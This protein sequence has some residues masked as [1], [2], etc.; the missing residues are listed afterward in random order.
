MASSVNNNGVGTE[1]LREIEEYLKKKEKANALDKRGADMAEEILSQLKEKEGIYFDLYKM[2]GQAKNQLDEILDT[3]NDYQKVLDDL[4][5]SF[6]DIIKKSGLGADEVTKMAEAYERLKKAEKEAG[7]RTNQGNPEVLAELQ[8]ARKEWS[9]YRNS[10]DSVVSD[11]AK[12]I[13]SNSSL[14][15]KRVKLEQKLG[16]ETNKTALATG[17]YNKNLETSLKKLDKQ[18]NLW[19]AT[20]SLIG[21]IFDAVKEVGNYWMQVQDRSFKVARQ[22]GL[23]RE[24]AA[25]MTQAQLQMTKELA[26]EYGVTQEQ[27]MKFQETYTQ[28][29]GKAV[30]LTKGE[31]ESMTVMSKLGDDNQA[32][33]W[34]SEMSKYGKGI[35]ETAGEFV[36]I[37]DKAKALGLNASK[38]TETIAKNLHLANSYTFIDG[39]NGIT[40]MAL[41]A[42]SLRVDMEQMMGAVDKF[43][44]IQ[45][46]IETTA[47]LQMLGGGFAAQFSNPMAALYG[48]LNDPNQIM[49]MVT[50]AVKGEAKYNEKTGEAE[51]SG[52]GMAKLRAAK[53]QLGVSVEQLSQ[54]AKS[55]A[56]NAEVDKAMGANAANMDDQHKSQIENLAH[57]NAQGQWVITN[58]ADNGQENGEIAV[59]KITPKDLDRISQVQPEEK[60][61]FKDVHNIDA[62]VA[63][64]AG[65]KSRAQLSL[66]AKEQ[67]S[68]FKEGV[69]ASAANTLHPAFEY[70][71]D[72]ANNGVL[73][74]IGS[75]IISTGFGSLMG[76]ALYKGFGSAISSLTGGS[77]KGFF[78][79]IFASKMSKE[80]ANS[81]FGPSNSPSPSSPKGGGRWSKNLSKPFKAAANIG[82]SIWKS[83]K[84]GKAGLIAAG[85]TALVAGG[86]ALFGGKKNEEETPNEETSSA[87]NSEISENNGTILDELKKHT[88]LLEKIAGAKAEDLMSG[89]GSGNN[90]EN[91]SASSSGAN[92][93]VK[94]AVNT[95]STIDTVRGTAGWL[96]KKSV[97][98]KV[99]GSKGTNALSKVAGLGGKTLGKIVSRANPMGWVGMGVDALNMGLQS[100]GLIK[101]NSN[102]AK[103]LNVASTT[104]NYAALGSMVGGPIG[105]LIG[106]AIGAGKGIYDNFI[107]NPEEEEKKNAANKFKGAEMGETTLED[108]ELMQKAAL[109]TISIHDILA[110][111]FQKENGLNADGTK[112]SFLQRTGDLFGSITDLPILKQAKNL[113]GFY[114]NGGIVPERAATGRIV[115]GDS[116]TG[117]KVPVMANSG[118]MILNKSEQNQMFKALSVGSPTIS[119]IS[120]KPY[121]G[122]ETIRTNNTPSSSYAPQIGPA[123]ISLNV[124]GTI[125]LDLGGRQANIDP[126]KLLDNS[127]FRSELTNIISRQLNTMGNG[128][129]YNK[130]GSTINTMRMYNKTR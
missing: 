3:Y 61:M 13:A 48:G 20:L 11:A 126:R 123:N 89:N 77:G 73:H 108:P 102:L 82:K 28:E 71:A 27:L 53:Q 86:Y 37:Q 15:D 99:V 24:Q 124:S 93:L 103:G 67:I 85:A 47:N 64:L 50:N 25:A 56:V 110:T 29:T 62:N 2:G 78:R 92:G 35:E 42:Q 100:T 58:Y 81:A 21:G 115:G 68:G 52:L 128:G 45:S 118:E 57:R 79:K 23:S 60:D 104:A 84:L 5:K 120:S 30:Q 41:K 74:G 113:L 18:N 44:D 65:G 6:E 4:K 114:S 12:D 63:A 14:M 117:D 1:N 106:G 8:N 116:Y 7:K 76:L 9:R 39:T 122:K 101:E 98:S 97:V 111:K 129:K 107:K 95:A 70:A 90:T 91:S 40:K 83:G 17:E 26:F 33:Q 72:S 19:G 125:R 51:I 22:M 55:Q 34:A 96:S 59:D 38:A 32:A 69:H 31:I 112:K 119:P 130:E 127:Q 80:A 16:E 54:L 94:N 10:Q 66:S 109:A 121:T 46:A 87:E 75:G 43:Q 36:L 105:G 49:D 88:T